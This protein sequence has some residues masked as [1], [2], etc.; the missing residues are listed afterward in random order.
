MPHKWF[1]CPDESFEG[2]DQYGRVDIET[3]LAHS[4]EAVDRGCDWTF[5]V[6]NYFVQVERD[7]LSPT[8][9]QRC[10]REVFLRHAADY[11]VDPAKAWART[12]GTLQHGALEK[13][14]EGLTEVR[15]QR[16]V[17]VDGV[18]YNL[19]GQADNIIPEQGLVRDWKTTGSIAR[20]LKMGALPKADHVEQLSLYG[21]MATA[22]EALGE[23]NWPE[24]SWVLKTGEVV[25]I[26][27]YGMKRYTFDLW[28]HKTVEAV[29]ATRLPL[30]ARMMDKGIEISKWRAEGK[31]GEAPQATAIPPVL[32]GCQAEPHYWDECESEQW[33]CDWC[34]VRDQCS[35][36]ALRE[37]LDPPM[38]QEGKHHL[39][40]PRKVK[41][42]SNQ[43]RSKP[44]SEAR[45]VTDN[46]VE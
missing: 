18:T 2:R 31:Q 24:P 14:A 12:R 39:V 25:Y 34:D 45:K 42:V 20:L 35:M 21:W 8:S 9:L 23:D 46:E 1:R 43:D 16:T 29:L 5:P 15:L 3:C 40:R 7:Y 28:D 36:L 4:K 26:D 13:Y 27:P 22:N 44:R 37:G 33:R 6:L 17:R 30:I 41:I 10:P 38:G 11:A 19:R 32:P